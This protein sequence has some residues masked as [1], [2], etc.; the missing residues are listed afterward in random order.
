[1]S[2]L[3]SIDRI[4]SKETCFVEGDEVSYRGTY[5][6]VDLAM[7]SRWQIQIIYPVFR[8]VPSRT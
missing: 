5:H 7:E 8:L 6:S 3:A 4:V 2:A 1:M